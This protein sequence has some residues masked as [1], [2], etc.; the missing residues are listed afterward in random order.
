V[1]CSSWPLTYKIEQNSEPEYLSELIVN[2]VSTVICSQQLLETV[3]T[4][5]VSAQR[6][7]SSTALSAWN[8][9]SAE[10]RHCIHYLVPF[11]VNWTYW[12]QNVFSQTL[13]H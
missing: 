4:R 5:I 3:S 6:A 1:L 2:Y 11:A 10:L 8:N 7:F 12:R 9:L 13:P